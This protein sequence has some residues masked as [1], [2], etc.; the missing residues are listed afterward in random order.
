MNGKNWGST[1]PSSS[2]SPL[3]CDKFILSRQ[4]R[5]SQLG[6]TYQRTLVTHLSLALSILY[7]SDHSSSET[8]INIFLKKIRKKM[9]NEIKPAGV[10]ILVGMLIIIL[11]IA[12]IYWRLKI[13]RSQIGQGPTEQQSRRL[14]KHIRSWTSGEGEIGCPHDRF[15]WV[16]R[17]H[18]FRREI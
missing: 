15:R 11:V 7:F 12:A 9:A 3:C 4:S 5:S 2:E 13:F 16:G 17:R 18:H 1:T 6:Q 8:N 10:A 14:F